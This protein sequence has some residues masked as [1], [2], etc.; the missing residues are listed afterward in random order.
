[1]FSRRIDMDVTSPCHNGPST[2]IRYKYSILGPE[3]RIWFDDGIVGLAEIVAV[4]NTRSRQF[5]F[6]LTSI[7]VGLDTKNSVKQTISDP[8][9]RSK[10]LRDGLR[11]RIE[12]L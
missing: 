8:T 3:S 6:E 5:N 2:G 7:D 12:R 9:E 1:M 11:T 10:I 4:L